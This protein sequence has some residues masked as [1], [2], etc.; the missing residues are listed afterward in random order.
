MIFATTLTVTAI[1]PRL[2]AEK[3]ANSP[4]L[5]KPVKC[6]NS[7]LENSAFKGSP[8]RSGSS[9]ALFPPSSPAWACHSNQPQPHSTPSLVFAEMFSFLCPLILQ[10]I[11][12]IPPDL[13]RHPGPPPLIPMP[14]PFK[15][16]PH[17]CRAL[18]STHAHFPLSCSLLWGQK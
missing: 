15:K 17:A 4:I 6:T 10:G 13:W 8:S 18:I 1:K 12:Q 3:R 9:P 7:E 2:L 11:F 5:Q 14:A 16:L